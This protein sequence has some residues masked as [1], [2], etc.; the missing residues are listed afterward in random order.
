MEMIARCGVSIWLVPILAWTGICYAD[1]VA[2]IM[3]D[4]FLIPAYFWLIKRLRKQL[5]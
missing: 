2:W 4:I 5:G 1:P 3:A